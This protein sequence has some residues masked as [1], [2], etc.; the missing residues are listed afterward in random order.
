MS[1][2][3]IISRHRKANYNSS[4]ETPMRLLRL[5]VPA[6]SLAVFCLILWILPTRASDLRIGFTV[7]AATLDPGAYTYRD[8]ETLPRLMYDGLTEDLL[9]P[10][11]SVEKLDLYTVRLKLAKPWP[12]LP[13]MLSARPC[14]RRSCARSVLAP[15]TCTSRNTFL[16]PALASCRTWASTLSLL[17]PGDTLA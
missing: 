12:V 3:T 4:E 10:L 16:H 13:G 5:F 15:L 2:A 14:G 6:S 9:G 17:P 8:N 11:T 7:D 1:L